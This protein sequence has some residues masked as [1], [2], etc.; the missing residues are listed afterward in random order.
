MNKTANPL[1]ENHLKMLAEESGISDQ[2]ILERGYR[3]ITN[4]GDLVK[5]GF[6]SAQ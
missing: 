1:S 4:E 3:T 5:Y 2:V 6:S